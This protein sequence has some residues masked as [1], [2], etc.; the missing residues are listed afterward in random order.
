MTSSGAKKDT[1]LSSLAFIQ[2]C[3]WSGYSIDK[4]SDLITSGS[5]VC[6]CVCVCVC[7][8]ERERERET[9]S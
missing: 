9:Y 1:V 8:R 3:V 5:D 6:V 7:E 2:M 4:S